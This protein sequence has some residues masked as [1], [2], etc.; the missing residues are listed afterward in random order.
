[1]SNTAKEQVCGDG[2]RS[3]DEM[4][5]PDLRWKSFVRFNDQGEVRRLTIADWHPAVD[6]LA[7][8]AAVPNEVTIQFDTARNL[9]LY[10]WYVYRFVPVAELQAHRTVEM[11]LRVRLGFDPYGGPGLSKLLKQAAKVG[12]V[13]NELGAEAL[14]QLRNNLAHGG[15]TLSTPGMAVVTLRAC[16]DLI[17]GLFAPKAT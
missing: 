6:E 16:R 13:K 15:S 4:K 2:F 8:C 1:M 14:R 9:L 12:L 17:N 11:A 3:V 10:S 5:E 7:L